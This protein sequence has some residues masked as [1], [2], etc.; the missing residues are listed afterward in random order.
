MAEDSSSSS[1]VLHPPAD[2]RVDHF[3]NVGNI[4]S[5]IYHLRHRYLSKQT[6]IMMR[7]PFVSI[8]RPHRADG[9][10]G[11]GHRRPAEID[12]TF[13]VESLTIPGNN[14]FIKG[15]NSFSLILE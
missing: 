3:P 14:T 13:T 9:I 1:S 15:I 11:P 7:P 4:T 12:N 10:L 8:H 2:G 6:Q 5:A